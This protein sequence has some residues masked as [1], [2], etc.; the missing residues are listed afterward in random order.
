MVRPHCLLPPL[1]SVFFLGRSGCPAPCCEGRP[2][3]FITGQLS[4]CTSERV[5]AG[6]RQAARAGR[7]GGRGEI[8]ARGTVGAP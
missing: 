5:P 3:W 7:E 1:S 4:V 2:L 8:R 6:S